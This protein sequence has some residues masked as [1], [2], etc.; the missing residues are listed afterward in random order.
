VGVP[1][2]ALACAVSGGV[3]PVPHLVA[4]SGA[5]ISVSDAAAFFVGEPVAVHEPGAA[6]AAPI[7]DVRTVAGLDSVAGL[8]VLSAPLTPGHGTASVVVP[9]NG[10]GGEVALRPSTPLTLQRDAAGGTDTELFV[11]G[12]TSVM[13]GDTVLVDGDGHLQTTPDQAQAT[14]KQVKFA[15][16]ET[17]PYSIV[18][19][20]PPSLTL[21]HGRSR[22]IGLGDSFGVGGTRD[23]TATGT[24]PLEP[25]GD[26]FSP[27]GFRY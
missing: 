12:P 22:V 4:E 23:T 16:G 6:G 1:S 18:V 15:P 3:A 11:V 25:H 21:L 5:R 2:G 26:Q 7:H 24:T 19:D 10:L 20:L 27:D 9:L 13:V 8:L 14:V 17:G